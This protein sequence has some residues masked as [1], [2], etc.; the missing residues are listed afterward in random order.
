MPTRFL[1]GGANEGKLNEMGGFDL[2]ICPY[3]E[4]G[5]GIFFGWH[6]SE[7]GGA[8]DAFKSG[9]DH[10]SAGNKGARIACRDKGVD[11]FSLRRRKPT[12]IEAFRFRRS[13]GGDALPCR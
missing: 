12:A 3:I 8:E 7:Q 11:F 4:D 1:I 9:E 2:N 5:N 6:E 13:A 10:F